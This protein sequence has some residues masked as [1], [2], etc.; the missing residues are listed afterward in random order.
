[1]GEENESAILQS[2]AVLPR[3]YQLSPATFITRRLS[4]LEKVAHPI[5]YPPIFSL[6]EHNINPLKILIP[7]SKTRSGAT[8]TAREVKGP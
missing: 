5:S 2:A 6:C 8:P 1:M 3:V 7:R 4:V